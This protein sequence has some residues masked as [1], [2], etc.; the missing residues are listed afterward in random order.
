MRAYLQRHPAQR[1]VFAALVLLLSP[2]IWLWFVITGSLPGLWWLVKA[3][4]AEIWRT[5]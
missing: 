4:W 5:K 1:R 3:Q 2:A